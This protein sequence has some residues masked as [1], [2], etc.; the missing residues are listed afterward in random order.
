MGL[1]TPS[2]PG[3]QAPLTRID[4]ISLFARDVAHVWHFVGLLFLSEA[5]D[6][7][8]SI[9]DKEFTASSSYVTATIALV[10]FKPLGVL[11]EPKEIAPSLLEDSRHFGRHLVLFDGDLLVHI[12]IIDWRAGGRSTSLR[13]FALHESS[14]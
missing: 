6:L 8:G 13:L 1:F 5:S 4:A 14:A 10:D 2:S 9:S 12:P 11:T 7:F 3:S